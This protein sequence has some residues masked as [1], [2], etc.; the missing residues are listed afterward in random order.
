MFK[1]KKSVNSIKTNGLNFKILFISYASTPS[2]SAT[3]LPISAGE[4]TT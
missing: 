3:F 1:H 4:S 2:T